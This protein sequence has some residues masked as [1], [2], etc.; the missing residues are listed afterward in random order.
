MNNLPSDQHTLKRVNGQPWTPRWWAVLLIGVALWVAATGTMFV[1]GNIILLPTIVLLG[2]FLVPVT[3]IVWYLD[4]DEGPA[5]SPRRIASAFIIAGVLGLIVASLLEFWLVYGPGTIGM[6]KVGFIEEFVK[7]AAIILLALGLRSYATRDGM[8]LGATIGFGFAAL[9]TSG[10]A[11][12][13][14]F[15]VQGQ[16]LVLSLPSVVFTEL[17]R[18]VLAPFGHGLWTAILGGV[19]FHAARKG[20][21]RLTWSVLVAYIS[22]SVLHAAFDIFGGITGYIVISIVGIVPLVYL[23]VWGDR[24]IPFRRSVQPVQIPA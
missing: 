24:G 4:H 21:L 10:Y 3:A 7:G 5:L 13:S 16:Q 17:V 2:S 9:E 12:A 1:T 23:W 11:L 18:A 8:L 14:L 20:H 15:V 19:I 22:V 6:L